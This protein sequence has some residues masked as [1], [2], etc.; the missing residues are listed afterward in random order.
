MR[1]RKE[2][3]AGLYLTVIVHLAVVIILLATSLSNQIQKE[4]SF[5]LDFSKVEEIEKM[6][7]EIERL[8]K[9]AAFKESIAQKLQAEIGSSSPSE[10]RNVAVDRG[11]LKDDR[12]TDAE[13]LYK[14]AQELQERL[15][16]GQNIASE[17]FAEPAPVNKEKQEA[18]QTSN[19]SGPSVVSYELEGRKASKLSIP[20][21]RCYGAGEVKVIITVNPA[22][23]VIA[24]TVDQSV[25]SSDK[26]LQS[27]A[28]RAARTSKF[29][30]SS[31]A[32][33]KQSG[34]IIYSFIA[35]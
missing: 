20:A 32:P 15:N 34:N 31:S 4:H 25:S 22:G 3:K 23:T 21:Y 13:Q 30:A 19:Y 24:A 8:Q 7:A 17:D 18:K 10:I 26:C 16:N 12:G 28:I 2:D 5:V 33:A 11:A 29:S 35:Q 14:D 1:I 6:Q 9:E 27:F